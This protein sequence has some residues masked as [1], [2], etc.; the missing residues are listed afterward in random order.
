M[1]GWTDAISVHLYY[2]TT[3]FW[4]LFYYNLIPLPWYYKYLYNL[5]EIMI[6]KLKCNTKDIKSQLYRNADVII[7]YKFNQWQDLN[8]NWSLNSSHILFPNMEK[9]NF[10][11]IKEKIMWL[12]DLGP[13]SSYY[14]E[15]LSIIFELFWVILNCFELF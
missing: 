12:L 13:I 14:F 4:Y 3:I 7:Q 1:T 10:T 15:F 9:D 2:C 8:I 5:Y 6:K 11:E